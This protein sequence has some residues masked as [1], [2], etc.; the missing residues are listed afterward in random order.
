LV[1]ID[2]ELAINWAEIADCWRV[3]GLR[4]ALGSAQNAALST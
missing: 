4:L 2:L 3:V 1:A